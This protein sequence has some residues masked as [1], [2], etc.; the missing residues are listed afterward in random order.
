MFKIGIPK[1]GITP[2]GQA[3]CGTSYNFKSCLYCIITYKRSGS[4]GGLMGLCFSLILM[5]G[6]MM[7]QPAAE[8]LTGI[9]L[10][11]QDKDRFLV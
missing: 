4:F 11:T 10:I 1:S 3:E 6:V 7:C 5:F 2:P 8:R 9:M